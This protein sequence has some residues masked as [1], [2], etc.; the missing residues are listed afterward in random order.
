MTTY[1]NQNHIGVS[2]PSSNEFCPYV[3][4]VSFLENLSNFIPIG[5][6]WPVIPTDPI[7]I[8]DFNNLI[9]PYG[10]YVCNG[11][12][13]N[14]SDLS[15]LVYNL[16]GRHTPNL[17]NDVFLMGKTTISLILAYG[18]SNNLLPHRHTCTFTTQQVVYT[19]TVSTQHSGSHGSSIC[20]WSN[21]HSHRHSFRRRWLDGSSGGP[22]DGQCYYNH[23]N[24]YHTCTYTSDAFHT[25]T[26]T[27]TADTAPAWAGAATM[28]P[29]SI[30][31][32]HSHNMTLDLSLPTYVG[33]GAL[34]SSTD[35]R[36][37]FMTA[38]YIIKIKNI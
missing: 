13:P 22:Y 38:Y 18:G 30:S 24:S 1:I 33:T 14:D 26:H 12:E 27:W 20:T 16:P 29:S 11:G 17:T 7:S 37:Q 8:N 10:F 15:C 32:N 5:S 34:P 28:M 19:N 4:D 9:I 6:V 2:I 3:V 23:L 21:D 25:H 35:N 36:P 31:F